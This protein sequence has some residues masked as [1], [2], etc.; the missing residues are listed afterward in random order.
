MPG[1]MDCHFRNSVLP[2][3]IVAAKDM[4]LW[5]P[6]RSASEAPARQDVR[7]RS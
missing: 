5:Q 6:S 7:H 2:T 1:S 3:V 4:H